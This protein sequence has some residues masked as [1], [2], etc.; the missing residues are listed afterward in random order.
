MR[1]DQAL[2]ADALQSDV[3]GGR[4]FYSDGL[5]PA[6][7]C[8]SQLS[9]VEL[10]EFVRHFT[11]L[12]LMFACLFQP[13]VSMGQDSSSRL[14]DETRLGSR[15]TDFN[16]RIHYGNSLEVSL[17]SGWLGYNIPFLFSRFEGDPWTRPPLNYTLVPLNL[18][19][20]WQLGDIKGPSFLRG[21]TDFTVG[22]SYTVITRGPESHYAALITALRRNF[23]QP[24]WRIVPYLEGRIGVGFTD[25][26]GPQGVPY[27]QGQDFTFTFILG[28]GVRHNITPRYG[29]STG[30]AYM[31]I[32]NLY[33]SEP[34][35]PNWGINVLGPTF[36]VNIGLGKLR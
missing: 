27:A 4:T 26:K 29:I 10:S 19:L 31:H 7:Q 14:S 2:V 24:N 17:D 18:S 9:A 30:I 5:T 36:G 12:A 20:R 34:K 23:V 33:L 25:A 1:T 28:G 21:N 13:C 22:G 35:V 8:R 6:G 15:I 16:T 32:S 11:C 3:C